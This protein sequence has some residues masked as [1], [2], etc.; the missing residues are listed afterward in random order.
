MLSD[1]SVPWILS[2]TAHVGNLWSLN[3]FINNKY[4]NKFIDKQLNKFINNKYIN[5]FI[6]K[7]ITS[8]KITL[9]L[10]ED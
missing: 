5:K 7:Q 6:D 3:K 8:R 4:I 9:I 1:W 2:D 10:L